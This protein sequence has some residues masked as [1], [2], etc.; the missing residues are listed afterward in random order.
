MVNQILFFYVI[1]LLFFFIGLEERSKNVPNN[2]IYLGL[3]FFVN[4]I[5]YYTSYSDTNYT[6]AAYFPLVLLIITVLM[7]FYMGFGYLIKATSDDSK[8]SEDKED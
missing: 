4:L 7:L 8:D 2:I 3:S 1:G 5:A 6:S